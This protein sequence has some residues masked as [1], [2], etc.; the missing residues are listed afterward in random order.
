VRL[1]SPLDLAF[2]TR[3][4][5]GP[6]AGESG[7]FLISFTAFTPSALRDLTHIYLASERL[8]D[9]ACRDLDGT[10]GIVAVRP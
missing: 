5:R 9:E 8:R 4:K 6:A 10:V 7:P 2:R 1:A 3:W